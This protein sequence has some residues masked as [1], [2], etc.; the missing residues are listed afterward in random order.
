[1]AQC[2][3]VRTD[4]SEE[5]VASTFNAER[6]SELGTMLVATSR[7]LMFFLALRFFPFMKMEETCSTEMSAVKR[8]IRRH[9]PEGII[10]NSHRRE[11][12][13]SYIALT[14]WAL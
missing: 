12:L 4:I 7:L 14:G 9:L 1:V 3:L 10:L 2:G 11:N 13:K 6:I 5:H 8:P